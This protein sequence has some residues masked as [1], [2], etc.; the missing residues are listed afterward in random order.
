MIDLNIVIIYKNMH[1]ILDMQMINVVIY[2]DVI[3]HLP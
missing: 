2:E 3:N 1:Q